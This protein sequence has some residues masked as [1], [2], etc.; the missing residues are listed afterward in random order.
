MGDILVPEP[1]AQESDAQVDGICCVQS[2]QAASQLHLESC[3]DNQVWI[4]H[5]TCN[6]IAFGDA[7]QE[8]SAAL[9]DDESIPD[10]VNEVPVYDAITMSMPFAVWDTKLR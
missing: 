9:L 7:D 8:D 2:P 6:I 3:L 1:R 5:A 10:P 4:I